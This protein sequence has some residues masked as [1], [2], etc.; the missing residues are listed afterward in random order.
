MFGDG[1][2]SFREF[3]MR[4]PLPLATVQD[5]VLQFLRGHDDCVLFGAQAVNAYVDEPRMTQDVD[6]LSTRAGELAQ[7]LCDFLKQRFHIA[8]R[9]RKVSEGRGYRI[10]QVQKAKNRHLVDIRFVKVLPPS[11]KVMDVLV[12]SPEELIAG[13]VIAYYQRQG[14]P[15]SFTDRRDLA[16]LL[17]RFPKLKSEIGSVRRRLIASGADAAILSTWASIVREKI[18][19]NREEDEF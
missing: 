4:E 15:K 11:R 10:F 13:K 6:L 7:E 1:S 16:E 9:I 14:N 18:S 17:L 2:L 5:A 8:V 12:V 3:V 19:R